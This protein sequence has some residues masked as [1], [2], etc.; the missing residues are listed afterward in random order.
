MQID[1]WPNPL[2]IQDTYKIFNEIKRSWFTYKVEWYPF[3]TLRLVLTPIHL[4]LQQQAQI[5]ERSISTARRMA[6][7]ITNSMVV[8]PCLGA[9]ALSWTRIL[10]SSKPTTEAMDA[11]VRPCCSNSLHS[12][13][14][15]IWPLANVFPLP[16]L[17]F[18]LFFFF[19]Y[20]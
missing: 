8:M 9:P 15:L 19:F 14:R 16:L 3:F 13:S 17:M 20:R 6:W 10:A 2:L 12:D 11:L 7:T 18:F 4:F 1:N 5:T